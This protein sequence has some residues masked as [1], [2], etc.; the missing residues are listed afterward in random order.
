VGDLNDDGTISVEDLLVLL[1][2]FATECP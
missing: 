1:A 2:A